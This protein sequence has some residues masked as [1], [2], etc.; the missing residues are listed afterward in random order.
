MEKLKVKLREIP[1]TSIS[2]SEFVRICVEGCKNEDQG[3]EFAK[4]LDESGNVIVLGNVV[5]LRPEQVLNS[6]G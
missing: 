4:M 3:A 6:G 2:Y 5:F 1:K